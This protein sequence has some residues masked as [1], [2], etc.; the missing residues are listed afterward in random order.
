MKYVIILRCTL[1]AALEEYE[2]ITINPVLEF[3]FKD[4]GQALKECS[5][6]FNS[7]RKHAA[8]HNCIANTGVLMNSKDAPPQ[9]GELVFAG[10]R[11]KQ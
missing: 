5:A 6:N 1:C 8:F 3:E 4:V 7:I 2:T 10:L 9:L 11:R